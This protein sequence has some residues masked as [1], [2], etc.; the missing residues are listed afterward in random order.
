MPLG[1]GAGEGGGEFG[2]LMLNFAP[3]LRDTLSRGFWI[4]PTSRLTRFAEELRRAPEAGGLVALL[5]SEPRG[6]GRSCGG[7]QPRFEP[8]NESDTQEDADDVG[9]KFVR[10]KDE[11]GAETHRVRQVE[12]LR[13]LG[14]TMKPDLPS[15]K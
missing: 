7:L 10:T 4:G 8:D 2:C 11:R 14:L 15:L 6:L 9:E 12:V 13:V 5:R 3:R 1:G